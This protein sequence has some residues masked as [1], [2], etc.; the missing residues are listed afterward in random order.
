MKKILFIMAVSAGMVAC[1]SDAVQD[2]A[3]AATEQVEGAADKGAELDKL[4]AERDALY[5]KHIEALDAGN[6]DDANKF[7]AEME[8]VDAEYQA[9]LKK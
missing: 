9:L 4:S 6:M 7:K 5:D 2:A 1:S 3:D 8:A